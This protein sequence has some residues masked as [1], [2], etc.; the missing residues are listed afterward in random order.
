MIRNLSFTAMLPAAA[1]LVDVRGG[2]ALSAE[3]IR[4]R[5][6]DKAAELTGRGLRPGARAVVA[7]PNPVDYLVAIFACWE[8]GLV[9]VAVNPGLRSEECE[10]VLQATGASIWL[11]PQRPASGAPEQGEPRPLRLDDPALILMTSGTTGRPKGIVHSVRSLLARAALNSAEIG[12]HTLRESLCVLPVFF[13]HGLIGNVLTPLLA[14]GRVHLWPSPALGEL[15]GL[16][17][18]LT[19]NRISFMSSVPSFWKLAL[20]VSARPGPVLERVHVGSAPLSIEHWRAI[21]EWCG[22]R[23]VFNMFGMTETANWIAGGS[24]D[25][26]E[27]RD[28]YVGRLWGGNVA[29]AADAAGRGEVLVQSPSMMLGYWQRPD[30]DE[31]AFVDGWFR[32]GDIGELDQAGNLILV[33]RSKSEI[34]RGGIK[35]Q[36]EEIDMLLERHEAIAEACAFGIPDAIAGEAVAAAIVLADGASFDP[37]ALKAWCRARVRDEAVP[38]RLFAVAAIPRND[39]G[40][41]VRAD[42]R[43]MVERQ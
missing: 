37:E 7:E 39:R 38:S 2:A 14:G 32:T 24:L 18:Y 10:N 13:G 23:Q 35:I 20:R 28:G 29:I 5:V 8:V 12:P 19:A 21:A 22:T 42:V 34:N 11:G 9:A 15:A 40:K 27:A 26:A 16:A 41:I 43:A 4:R 17:G 1:T 30:L 31:A 33:G 6:G 3:G 36:A 25:E